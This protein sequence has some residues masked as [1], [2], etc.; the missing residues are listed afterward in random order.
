[1][2][3]YQ[4]YVVQPSTGLDIRIDHFEEVG[5]NLESMVQRPKNISPL[6]VVE[7]VNSFRVEE[8]PVTN[9]KYIGTNNNFHVL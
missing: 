9:Y 3:Y 8:L 1:M 4:G 5:I 6:G 2:A 7:L